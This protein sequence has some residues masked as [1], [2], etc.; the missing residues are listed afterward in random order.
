M[1]GTGE[2]QKNEKAYESVVVEIQTNEP[3]FSALLCGAWETGGRGVSLG[4]SY[5]TVLGS[6]AGSHYG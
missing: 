2:T 6:L 5:Y 4:L 3:W 1:E